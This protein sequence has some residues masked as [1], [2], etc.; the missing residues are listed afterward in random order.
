[1]PSILTLA[2]EFLS[3]EKFLKRP[4]GVPAQTNSITAGFPQLLFP[5]RGIP[6]TSAPIPLDFP[7][8]LRDFCRPYSRAD[9]WIVVAAV[10]SAG[11]YTQ[12]GSPGGAVCCVCGTGVNRGLGGIDPR[13]YKVAGAADSDDEDYDPPDNHIGRV[14]F[15]VRYDSHSETLLIFMNIFL[16]PL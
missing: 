15:G 8:Y 5:S 2:P 4:R 12:T 6:A 1:L 9:L 13:L 16:N 10:M 7:R 14:W 3:W 11:T